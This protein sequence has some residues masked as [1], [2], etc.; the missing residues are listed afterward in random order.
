MG[1]IGSAGFIDEAKDAKGRPRNN[2]LDYGS[3][4]GL[5]DDMDTSRRVGMQLAGQKDELW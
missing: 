1:R 4:I 2:G 5:G 3:R